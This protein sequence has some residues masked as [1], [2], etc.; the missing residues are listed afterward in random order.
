MK[1]YVYVVFT[2]LLLTATLPALVSCGTST[3]TTPGGAQTS[4]PPGGTTGG[5]YKPVAVTIKDFA[6]NPATITVATGTT[7]T[8]TN[9]DSVTHTVTS[10]TG[11]FDSGDIHQGADFSYTF[12][13]AGDY[14]YHCSIHTYMK[15]HV[16][17]Q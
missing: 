14:G 16:I 8:W 9:E 1:K 17:V 4:P 12:N 10:D 15:G 11:V 3:T 6:F 7:V 2:V 5:D 13:T